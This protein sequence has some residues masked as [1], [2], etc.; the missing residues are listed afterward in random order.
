M[1]RS[2]HETDGKRSTGARPLVLVG[3]V[4]ALAVVGVVVI[5]AIESPGPRIADIAAL[6]RQ[7]DIR[8]ASFERLE[9]A[10]E[11]MRTQQIDQARVLLE[12]IIADDPDFYPGHLLLGSVHMELG[13]LNLAEQATQKAYELEPKDPDVLYQLGLIA[14]M[15]GELTTAAEHLASAIELLAR[16]QQPPAPGYHIALADVH[17]RDGQ[18]SKG[19]EQ[20]EQAVQADASEAGLEQAIAGAMMAG[21]QVKHALAG[22]LFSLGKKA[23][24]AMLFAR[25]ADERQDIA[26]WQYRA[27][28][29]YAQLDQYDLAREY[30]QR[31]VD[32]DPSNAEYVA[33]KRDID[34]ALGVDSLLAPEPADEDE[35]EV[36]DLSLPRLFEQP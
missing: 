7:N 32:L 23:R 31:A 22:E 20:V 26:A 28:R 9:Q 17:F 35:P 24:A 3:G 11:M 14:S 29:V 1:S 36:Q 12:Q 34:K 19:Y 13:K 4:V 6:E 10:H 8:T 5:R 18:S 16:L 27:A 2:R 21:E 25:A 15:R 33:L 30:I